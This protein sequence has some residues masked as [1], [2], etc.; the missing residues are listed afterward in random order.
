MAASLRSQENDGE[1]KES[2]IPLLPSSNL[3]MHNPGDHCESLDKEG[4]WFKKKWCGTLLR[5][6]ERH[7][8]PAAMLM[9]FTH[10][11]FHAFR[12]TN[13]AWSASIVKLRYILMEIHLKAICIPKD[14]PLALII[15]VSSLPK[16]KLYLAAN[17]SPETE[18]T[19]SKS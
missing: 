7:H 6:Q 2:N 12:I 3:G 10:T 15:I 13:T 19:H 1:R 5:V 11:H 18:T 9:M 16:C 4:F 14:G 8:F 17:G